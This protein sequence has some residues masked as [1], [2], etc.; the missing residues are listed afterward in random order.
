MR[1]ERSTGSYNERRYGRPYIAAV[2]FSKSAQGECRWG[3]WVG[4]AG[5]EGILILDANPGDI[6]MMGQKDGRNSRNSAPDYYRV[7][8]DGSLVKMPSKAAAYRAWKKSREQPA[9]LPLRAIELE[10]PPEAPN[11]LAEFSTAELM[12][13]LERRGVPVVNVT[14]HDVTVGPTVEDDSP[15]SAIEV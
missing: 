3:E 12:A 15:A 13:E 7:A 5:C 11:P 14:P 2:D 1:I 6:V 8:T 4:Q 10:G 9:N